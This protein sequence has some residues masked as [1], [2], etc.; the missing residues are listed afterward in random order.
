MM[1]KEG[2]TFSKASGKD[3]DFVTW[4]ARSNGKLTG[5]HDNANYV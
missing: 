2:M 1:G 3:S 4:G 5:A